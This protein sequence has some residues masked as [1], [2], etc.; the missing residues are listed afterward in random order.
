M[1]S[2]A[3]MYFI[4]FMIN[5]FLTFHTRFVYCDTVYNMHIHKCK[6]WNAASSCEILFRPVNVLW[7]IHQQV[8]L[9][10]ARYR[11]GAESHL[12]VPRIPMKMFWSTGNTRLTMT[13]SC[14]NCYTSF[15][16]YFK[17][18]MHIHRR[19]ARFRSHVEK[20]KKE[21]TCQF[22]VYFCSRHAT[23]SGN[24]LRCV[25]QSSRFLNNFIP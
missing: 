1:V 10:H 5:L 8:M 14:I 17:L 4:Y 16:S 24:S 21:R 7:I 18:N 6:L 2:N 23:W 22:S 3:Y 13:I 25:L 11:S 12:I 19:N 20:Y 15:N 9:H